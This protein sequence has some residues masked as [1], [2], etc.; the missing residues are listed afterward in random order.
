MTDKIENIE[1]RV[2]ALIAALFQLAD[3]LSKVA[4]SGQQTSLTDLKRNIQSAGN[5]L[6][7]DLTA[8]NDG[9]GPTGRIG[10]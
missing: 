8:L 9:R 10:A 3:D 7:Q 5:T 4:G 6:R 2:E 1:K